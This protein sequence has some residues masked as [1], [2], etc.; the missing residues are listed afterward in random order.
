VSEGWIP[1]IRA[2]DEM[3]AE[4]RRR[5]I[6]S[7]R[8]ED[9][10][11]VPEMH[12]VDVPD[13]LRERIETAMAKYPEVRSAALPALWAVQRQYGWCT[14]EGI[15]Q[16]AAV[17]GVTPAYLESL[18]TF[19]D[20]F[21]TSPVGRHQVLVCH[22]ISCWLRGS[23]DLMRSFCEAAGIDADDADHGGTSS[24]DGE[25]FLKG[26]ECMGACDLAPMA[27][28]DDR[29]YGPLAPDD[30]RVAV[31]QL[32]T[33]VEVLPDKALAKRAAA[34]GPEPEPDPRVKDVE[35]NPAAPGGEAE[36]VAG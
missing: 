6:E 29:Y 12:E 20:L 27:S 11:P 7:M 24:A 31:E 16:A 8:P 21:R 19:Y 32:R 3:S 36:E 35:R 4:E 10:E 22:N 18:T 26:F 2:T 1:E 33:G 5:L 30:A 34:G 28:I 14:P 25:L 17:M 23:D 9:A 13:E 15:R